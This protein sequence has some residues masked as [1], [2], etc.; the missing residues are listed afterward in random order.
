MTANKHKHPAKERVMESILIDEAGCWNWSGATKGKTGYGHLSVYNKSF[1]AHRY[2]WMAYNGEIPKKMFVCHKCDNRLCV[3]PEHLFLGN[4]ADN[5]RD[6]V[7]KKRNYS[8]FGQ[9]GE[10]NYWA[11]LTNSQAQDIRARRGEKVKTLS[12]EYDVSIS[13]IYKIWGYKSYV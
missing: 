12:I 13:T 2:S 11:K 4:N 5:M 6:C 7:S 8:P 10:K 9:S 1:A 3:N